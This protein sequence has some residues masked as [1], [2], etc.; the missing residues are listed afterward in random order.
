MKILFTGGG[1]G[2]HFYP[3]I[4][5]AEQVLALSKEE[6]LIAPQLFFMAP[7]PYD[8][9]VLFE[10]EIT[11]IRVS[12]GK[13]RRYASL[14]NITDIFKIAWAVLKATF[15]MFR[16]YPDVVV[17]KG[18]FGSF[19]ALFAARFWSIPVIIHES[20]SVPGKVNAWAG[21][22]ATRVAVS[23]AN[24]AS[25]F[26]KETVAYTGNPLRREIL[27]E[28]VPARSEFDLEKDTKVIFVIGGSLGSTTLNEALLQNLPDLVNNYE[29]VHQTGK[30]NLADMSARAK[31]LLQTNP[32]M[33]RYHPFGYLST[34]QVSAAGKLCDLVISRAGSTIFEI[35]AWGKPSILIPITDSNGD[36]QREN[37]YAYSENGA[38]D[39]LE[40]ANLTPTLFRNQ[41]EKIFGDESRYKL[42]TERARHFAKL[43]AAN[44]IAR[45][46]LEIALKHEKP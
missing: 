16:I 41:I 22:F 46:I 2:G 26:K 9:G 34:R 13:L 5:I 35:A 10:H 37:A 45:E 33:H 11:F 23:F 29:I 15:I 24:A 4:A 38:A 32:F 40:E 20:D 39:V 12:T 3:I 43:D 14:K 25:S 19:P 31:V 6:R 44:V 30:A 7:E 18:G 28:E 1:S 42:M 17:G 27:L 21:K 36:H 8:E